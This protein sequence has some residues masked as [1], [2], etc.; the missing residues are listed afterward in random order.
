MTKPKFKCFI[1]D[2]STTS[3]RKWRKHQLTP[4]LRHLIDGTI[5]CRNCK[6]LIE[7]H[8]IPVLDLRSY[9]C[10]HCNTM[11]DYTI[12]LFPPDN[13]IFISLDEAIKA[14]LLKNILK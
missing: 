11:D 12:D 5:T 10:P 7:L 1:H 4:K 9:T 8:K 14:G 6:E 2:F 13:A 3:S